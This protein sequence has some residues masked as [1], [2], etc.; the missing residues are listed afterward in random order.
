M[1]VLGAVWHEGR[2][3]ARET[4]ALVGPGLIVTAGYLDPGDWATAIEAGS[5]YQYRFLF[6]V[7]LAHLLAWGLQSLAARLGLVTGHSLSV[8]CREVY[9]PSICSL[10]WLLSEVAMVALDV[11]QVLGVAVGLNLCFHIPMKLAILLTPLDAA[12]VAVILG[13]RRGR[14]IEH[15]AALSLFSV[16]F[17]FV[18]RAAGASAGVAWNELTQP[19][20]PDGEGA[21]MVAA[22][23]GATAS[24]H[25]INL[26][27]A[28]VVPV[29]A[30]DVTRSSWMYMYDIAWCLGASLVFNMALIV[31]SASTFYNNDFMVVTLQSAHNLLEGLLSPAIAPFAFGFALIC[32]SQLSSL[33]LTLAGVSVI[34]GLQGLRLHFLSRR[35]LTRIT[36]VVLSMLAMLLLGEQVLFRIMILSQVLLCLH[37]PFVFVPLVRLTSSEEV[38]GPHKTSLGWNIVAGAC[39]VFVFSLNAWVLLD[40]VT[41]VDY[42]RGVSVDQFQSFAFLLCWVMFAFLT[43]LIVYPVAIRRPT[44]ILPGVGGAPDVVVPQ[45]DVRRKKLGDR[46]YFDEPNVVIAFATTPT[47]TPT[48]PLMSTFQRV[49]PESTISVAVPSEAISTITGSLKTVTPPPPRTSSYNNFLELSRAHQESAGVTRE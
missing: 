40:L 19:P 27:S 47:S 9:P 8:M 46:G 38:M 36:A 16:V 31:V 28:L 14:T 5:R 2:A 25:N 49:P 37:L 42:L 21:Y 11:A 10:L 45:S 20:R 48:P 6:V 18:I 17:C 15:I 41:L 39:L 44:R 30:Q 26:H 24:S 34:D 4:M 33:T 32:A 22:I 7:A 12:F 1:S 13:S 35:L 43:I 3:I 29:A 23:V